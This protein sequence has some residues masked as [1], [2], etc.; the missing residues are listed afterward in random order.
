MHVYCCSIILAPT[1]IDQLINFHYHFPLAV[2]AKSFI[3]ETK[4]L[5]NSM[6][7]FCFLI[8]TMQRKCTT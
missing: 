4:I 8:I 2:Q 7:A 3:S 5:I 6:K 1:A